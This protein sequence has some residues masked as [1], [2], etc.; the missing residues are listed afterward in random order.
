VDQV[1]LSIVVLIFSGLIVYDTGKAN[2]KPQCTDSDSCNVD[3]SSQSTE[4]A[5]VAE[6]VELPYTQCIDRDENCSKWA[7]LGYCQKNHTKMLRTCALSC[8]SCDDLDYT[9]LSQGCPNKYP[10]CEDCKDVLQECARWKEYGECTKHPGYMVLNCAKTCKYCHLQS[11]Y[12]LRCPTNAEYM[13]QT[14]AFPEAGDLNKMFA[15]IVSYYEQHKSAGDI[16]WDLEILSRDPWILKFDNFFDQQEAD[17]II[18]AAGTFERSTDVGKQDETGHFAKVTS[19]SRTS[20][21]AWCHERC[22][23]HPMVQR[24]MQRAEQ[25]LNISL[26]NSEHLQILEYHKG[27]F[28]KTHHDYIPTQVGM[29]CGPRI[30]TWFMYLSDVEEGG[31]TY[32]PRLKIKNGPK[33]GRVI[34]WPSVRDDAPSQIDSRTYHEAQPVVKGVKYAANAWFHLYDF[35]TPNLWTCTG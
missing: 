15:N 19:T 30:L 13:K 26:D 12:S 9:E 29:S 35:Q 4:S 14:C 6:E 7:D 10:S 34:L 21:N 5:A 1:L 3:E 20:S 31:A 18:E 17:G 25:L 28:Y 27:Q 16:D 24:V 33:L 8:D 32:F 11:N 23:N 2:I 22:W